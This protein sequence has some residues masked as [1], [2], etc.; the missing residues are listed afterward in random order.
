[1]TPDSVARRVIE[2][3]QFV[4]D[5]SAFVDVRIERSKGKASY[6]FI[7]PGV[8]QNADQAINLVEPHGFNIGAATLPHG[9]IN[10]QHLHF[11]AEVFICT[12]GKFRLNIGEF[13][14]Q[15]IDI[16]EGEIFSAPTWVFRGFENIGPDD[17][18]LFAVLGGDDTGGI[19]WAPEVLRE[20]AETGLYLGPDNETLDALAGDDVSEALAP[21]TPEDLGNVETW[22]DSELA[23]RMVTTAGLNWSSTAL[24]S[25]A[26]QSAG[27]DRHEVAV[28]PVLGNG[29]S[30]QRRHGAPMLD[31]H[32][33]SI[34]WVRIE[35]GSSMGSH[36]LAGSQAMLVVEGQVEAA[37]GAAELAERVRPATGS[38]ISFPKG[39]WRDVA[40]V[41]DEPAL[42]AVVCNGDEPVQI[43]WSKA[44]VEAANNNGWSRDKSGFLAPSHLVGGR[45]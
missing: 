5:T 19:L 12:R 4:A 15:H 25:T 34:D 9:V 27:V 40:N 23:E 16:S 32:G 39:E 10:N 22:T 38:I 3:S 37:F 20:A 31:P 14:D 28:A 45:A 29:L 43:E 36:R 17:G 44:I 30:E 18:W 24:L 26:G 41:G 21:L 42:L 8:S 11:T 35:P 13:A 6:S 1:M 2:P 7:G 33:F